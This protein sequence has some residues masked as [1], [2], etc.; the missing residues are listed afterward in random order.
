M[1]NSV[2]G[3]YDIYEVTGIRNEHRVSFPA[4]YYN[5]HAFPYENMT[6]DE[7]FWYVITAFYPILHNPLCQYDHKGA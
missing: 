1:R 6:K 7:L 4:G 5:H 2:I 3:S